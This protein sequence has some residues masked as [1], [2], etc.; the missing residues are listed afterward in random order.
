MKKMWFYV[1][2]CSLVLA[3]G[4]FAC[5]DDDDD[6]NDDGSS[7]S[8]TDTDSDSDTDTDSDSDSDT[9]TDT[10]TDADGDYWV[11]GYCG[12]FGSDV[13]ASSDCQDISDVGCCDADGNVVWCESGAL[14]CIPC[15]DSNPECGWKAD[16]G[17]YDCGTDGSGDPSETY[18]K[19]C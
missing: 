5:G 10:D 16:A 12:D 13:P 17:Y 14:W 3:F 11:D 9:D 8:D 18:P 7:D 15:A 4:A 1:M 6:D 19:D 2:I